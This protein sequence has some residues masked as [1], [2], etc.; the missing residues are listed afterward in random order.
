LHVAYLGYG[1]GDDLARG[2][3]AGLDALRGVATYATDERTGRP[4]MNARTLAQRLYRGDAVPPRGREALDRLPSRLRQSAREQ[5][6]Q[7]LMSYVALADAWLQAAPAQRGGPPSFPQRLRD[8]DAR[9][10]RAGALSDLTTLA[11]NRK[12]ER[13]LVEAL[14]TTREPRAVAIP[15]V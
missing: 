13:E 2:A 3:T 6:G 7:S 14:L 12:R 8:A 15:F 9:V 10:K 5:A 4:R 11:D 1:R